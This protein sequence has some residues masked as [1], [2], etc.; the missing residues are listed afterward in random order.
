MQIT[1]EKSHLIA[2]MKHVCRAVGRRSKLPILDYA[3]IVTGTGSVTIEGTNYELTNIQTIAADV[4][5]HGS[6]LVDAHQLANILSKL[7]KATTLVTLTLERESWVTNDKDGIREWQFDDVTLDAGKLS[8]KLTSC[9]YCDVDYPDFKAPGDVI[10]SFSIES[11]RMLDMIDRVKIAVSSE[12]TR[13]YLCGINLEM[14][15]GNILR[16]VA[17]DGHRLIRCDRQVSET[18]G[19]LFGSAG[20]GIPSVILP[21]GCIKTLVYALKEHDGSDDV[22]CTI[23]ASRVTIKIG[24]RT[25]VTK[26]IDGSFPDYVRVIPQNADVMATLDRAEVSDI[27]SRFAAISERGRAIRITANGIVSLSFKDDKLSGTEAVT[28]ATSNG[29]WEISCNGNYLAE[30]SKAIKS[31]RITISFGDVGSPMLIRGDDED[32]DLTLLMPMRV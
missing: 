17:S 4:A 21:S 30:L 10:G 1:V 15:K 3:R 25:I 27:V 2:A 13:Y 11:D 5:A 32:Q 28:G 8:L 26:L 6:A 7:P 9:N 22:E 31:D 24:Q 18:S 23:C 16:M 12:E 19:A 29:E 14:F 20:F